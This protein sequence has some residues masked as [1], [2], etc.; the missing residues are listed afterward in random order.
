MSLWAFRAGQGNRN[1]LPGLNSGTGPLSGLDVETGA[2]SGLNL[3]TGALS[4][5]DVETVAF[6]G[7]NSGT[8]ALSRLD[9]ETG[10]HLWAGCGNRSPLWAGRGN[11]GNRGLRRRREERGR[12]SIP[13]NKVLLR[14][15]LCD[16]TV[17]TLALEV[18]IVA[19]SHTWTEV[20][21]SSGSA[22]IRCSV[23]LSLHVAMV[24]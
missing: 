18:G 3:G 6:S 19:G 13:V 22:A 5:L 15:P 1:R 23:A 9:M 4:G 20:T 11:R 17:I 8:G 10:A 16:H 2:L 7:L 12:V 21:C 24:R 14:T